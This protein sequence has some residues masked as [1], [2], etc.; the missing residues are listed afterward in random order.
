MLGG[1]AAPLGHRRLARPALAALGLLAA[2]CAALGPRLRCPEEGGPAW[3]EVATD[4]FLVWT[5]LEAAEALALAGRLEWIRGA[6]VAAAWLGPAEPESRMAVV[7]LRAARELRIFLREEAPGWVIPDPHQPRLV[8]AAP[9][10]ELPASGVARELALQLADLAWLRQ[11]RWL[12][13]G[14][15]AY[16]ETVTPLAGGATALVGMEPRWVRRAGRV[17]PGTLMAWDAGDARHGGDEFR[18]L[19]ASAW[20]LTHFLADDRGRDFTAFQGRLGAG[21]PPHLAWRKSFPAYAPPG[22]LDRLQR[23]LDAWAERGRLVKRAVPV[24][25]AASRPSERL[26]QPAEA[27]AL[28]ALLLL[29]VPPERAPPLESRRAWATEESNQALA[30]DPSEPAALFVSIWLAPERERSTRARA[31]ARAAPG[32][33]RIWLLLAVTLDPGE[34]AE[35]EAALRRARELAP[36]QPSVLSA[37]A[38]ELVAGGKAEEAVAVAARAVELAAWK[39]FP[40]DVLAQAQE[41]LG[42]CPEALAASRRATETLPDWAPARDRKEM[43]SR[44]SGLEAR[45]GA[46]PP[47]STGE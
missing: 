8:L 10:G 18:A 11:P 23:D 39:A 1:M 45:C 13:A 12:R 15:A 46:G 35:R 2:G 44:L 6:V 9:G 4:H 28:W 27:H 31:A 33:W 21:S 17:R 43:A 7:A 26:M 32:D 41:A 22:G 34:A 37:L 19:N 20:E 47:G 25:P 40:L 3:R 24:A 36:D 42:R 38:R 14:L 16:L 5:D 30:H 29:S